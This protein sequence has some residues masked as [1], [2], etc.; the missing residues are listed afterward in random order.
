MNFVTPLPTP[1]PACPLN[2]LVHSLKA[3]QKS[4]VIVGTDFVFVDQIS[5][6]VIQL[7]VTLL[8]GLPV[9]QEGKSVI[10]V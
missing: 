6:E 9:R 8:H 3:G 7:N 10:Y 2:G 4:I 5:V 1:E